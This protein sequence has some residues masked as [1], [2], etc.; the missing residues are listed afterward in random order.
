LEIR[1]VN[2]RPFRFF[3]QNAKKC[4]TKEENSSKSVSIR[5]KAKYQGQKERRWHSFLGFPPP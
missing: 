4:F 3:K 1:K 5:A 2:Q